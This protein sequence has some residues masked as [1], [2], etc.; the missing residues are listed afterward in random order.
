[1]NPVQDPA[2][3]RF[4][5]VITCPVR[6]G[7]TEVRTDEQYADDPQTSARQVLTALL[8][9][10]LEEKHP[11]L[12]DIADVQVLPPSHRQWAH[13]C[14]WAYDQ[15]DEQPALDC[16]DCGVHIVDDDDTDPPVDGTPCP[17]CHGEQTWRVIVA[18]PDRSWSAPRQV[19]P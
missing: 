7:W 4:A 11:H 8:D 15:H 16:E 18:T 9:S 12:S 10:H 13:P 1:M 17:E 14:T 5:W 3:V 2:G 19:R 6:C